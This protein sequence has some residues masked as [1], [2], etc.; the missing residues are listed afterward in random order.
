MDEA[1][2]YATKIASKCRS[3]KTVVIADYSFCGNPA[4]SLSIGRDDAA[5]EEARIIGREKVNLCRPFPL[6]ASKPH[7]THIS[8]VDR[9]MNDYFV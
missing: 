5:P 8:V 7:C 2:A 1:E 6:C 9:S 3:L 4:L